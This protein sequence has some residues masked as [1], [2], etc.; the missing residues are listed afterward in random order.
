[1]TIFGPSGLTI[2]TQS[3]WLADLQA[4]YK[5]K[6][7]DECRVDDID[8]VFG[9]I[10]GIQSEILNDLCSELAATVAALLPS[11][12]ADALLDELVKFNG[13]TRNLATKSSVL[14]T[15]TANSAGSTVPD[16]SL[17]GTS[18]GVQFEIVGPVVLIPDEVKEN[19]QAYAVQEGALQADAGTVTEILTPVFGWEA[20]TNPADAEVGNAKESNAVLRQ[21]R[22]EAAQAVGLHHPS[23]IKKVLADLDDV[24][25][26]FV[27][28]NNGTTVNENLVPPQ[29]IRCILIG[30][31][32]QDIADTL[33]G[34]HPLGDMYPQGAGSI[35]GGIGSWGD[36]DVGVDDGEG[37]TDTM[38]FDRG[39]YIP[40]Y[41]IV[42]TNVNHALYPM[43]GEQQIKDYILQF[44]AGT[45][46]IN[47]VAVPKFKLGDDVV[48][49]R[50]YTPCN[51]VPGH[52]VRQILISR[53]PNPTS[54]ADLPMALHEIATTDALK[55]KVEWVS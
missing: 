18:T 39:E 1:M 5:D 31:D 53:N 12:S 13:I 2:P 10:C 46:E 28:V 11:T 16:G 55:I 41:I 3:E 23:I 50:L 14:L 8:G 25:E 48:S 9:R 40:I 54:D 29:H 17:V 27:E 15:L 43:D 22:W 20:V 4:R 35:A 38:H 45:L 21:R 36:V 19:V 33:F 51:A 44:F 37:N 26:V 47:D 34:L 7:G 52:S 30:G 6:F 32:N 49:S 42:Q 24:V